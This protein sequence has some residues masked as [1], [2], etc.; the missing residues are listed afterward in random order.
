[1]INRI[2]TIFIFLLSLVPMSLLIIIN[3]V[4]QFALYKSLLISPKS[5]L[6]GC[7]LGRSV[8]IGGGIRMDNVT[9]GDFTYFAGQEGG[10]FLSH[11]ANVKFGKFCSVGQGLQ[12][13]TKGHKLNNVSTYP[14]QSS[15]CFPLD[16]V[17]LAIDQSMSQV[18]IGNDVWIGANSIILGGV[19][20]GDGA[21]IGAGSVVTHNV[22]SY[23]VVA[24]NPAKLIRYRFKEHTI[25]ELIRIQWWNWDL[26]KIKEHHSILLSDRVDAFTKNF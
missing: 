20:V 22:P 14:F 26:Q 9:I 12:V 17:G 21:V 15:I 24:G 1:M 18:T 10:G 6:F 8:L 5:F 19:T 2:N 25:N 7:D 13:L 16:Y 3:F 4:R 11:M 23:S